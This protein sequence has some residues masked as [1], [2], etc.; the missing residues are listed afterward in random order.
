MNKY[1]EK[2][3]INSNLNQLLKEI[4]ERQNTDETHESLERKQN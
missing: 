1:N 4:I 3:W 2:I